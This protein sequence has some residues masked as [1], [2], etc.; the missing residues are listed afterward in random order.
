MTDTGRSP[1]LA[2]ELVARCIV[3]LAPTAAMGWPM[4]QPQRCHR[5]LYSGLQRGVLD[6]GAAA[7]A[8]PLL[9]VTTLPID[10]KV[11]NIDKRG[12][13]DACQNH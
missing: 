12:S 2:A 4:L 1:Q 5:Y 7:V 13:F 6:N 3:F 8:F 9:K 11:G 10:P